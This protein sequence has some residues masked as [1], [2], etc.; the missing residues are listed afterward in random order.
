MSAPTIA[1]ALIAI[2]TALAL[3]FVGNRRIGVYILLYFGA[4]TAV[5]AMDVP[6]HLTGLIG[7]G[8]GMSA[9]VAALMVHWPWKPGHAVAVVI[10]INGGLWSGSLRGM[11]ASPS[12]CA[13]VALVLLAIPGRRLAHMKAPHPAVALKIIA[14]WIAAIAIL[15]T[16]LPLLTTPGNQMDHRE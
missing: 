3:S 7:V 10:A 6:S 4:V 5:L 15:T 13:V 12:E 11:I 8:A 1:L 16:A 14:G 9:I 2:A